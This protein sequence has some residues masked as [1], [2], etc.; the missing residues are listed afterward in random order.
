MTSLE[1]KDLPLASRQL[2]VPSLEEL[3]N[4]FRESLAKNFS[5]VQVDIVDCPDLTQ[6]P[7]NLAASGLCGNP[8]ILEIGGPA[9]LLPNVQR[10]KLYDVRTLLARLEYGNRFFV[11]GAGAGP[12]PHLNSNC[13]LIMNLASTEVEVKNETRIASVN[14]INEK[15]VLE[16]LPTKETRFALLANFFV[17]QGKPGKVLK[18]YAKNRTGQDDFI[19]AMRKGL[20]SQYKDQLVGLG[21]TFLMNTGKAKQHVMRDFSATPLNT[22]KQLNQW[23]KFYDMSTPLVALGTFVSSETLDLDLREQHFHSF[24]QHGEGGHY[25]ID[26]TPETIEYLGY[27]NVGDVLHRFDQPPELLHFGKD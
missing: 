9:Y 23:L 20:Q 15:C 16:G 24:S 5:D 17:S 18:V 8:K 26:T 3:K 7:F 13:E 21:G 10:D 25:H 14:T 12:W 19:A 22:E 2:T 4:V 1:A 6:Q 27:F 11:V